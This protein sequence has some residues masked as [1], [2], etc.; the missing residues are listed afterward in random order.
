LP[1]CTFAEKQTVPK[2]KPQEKMERLV[3]KEGNGFAEWTI[4]ADLLTKTAKEKN[5]YSIN[6]PIVNWKN[7]GELSGSKGTISEKELKIEDCT[8]IRNDKKISSKEIIFKKQENK[9][10]LPFFYLESNKIKLNGKSS[11]INLSNKKLIFKQGQ[12]KYVY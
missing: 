2:Q 8:L 11:I 7:W 10:Y 1:G 3:L 6:R 12:G 5:V 4:T 9:L